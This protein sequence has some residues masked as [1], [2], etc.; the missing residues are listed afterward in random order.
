MAKLL[1]Q[2]RDTTQF[3]IHGAKSFRLAS[4]KLFNTFGG[5]LQNKNDSLKRLYWADKGKTINQ[6]DQSGAEALI[7]AY[8]CRDGN[9]RALFT[10]GVKPHVFVA[11][12]IFSDVWKEE[13]IRDGIDIHCDIDELLK[14]SI[15]D[16]KKNPWFKEVDKLIKSSDEWED[17]RR[18]YYIAKQVCHASNYGSSHHMLSLNTLDKS[19]GR[20][21]IPLKESKRFMDIYHGLFP[22]I[23]EDFQAYVRWCVEEN[24]MLYNLLGH[25][26]VMTCPTKGQMAQ[27][28]WK[29]WYA[30]I[31]QSTVAMITR[32][33][34]IKMQDFIEDTKV[35]WD[36]LPCDTHDSFAVQSP[37]SESEQ[38]QKIM[39]SF[40]EPELTN[41]KGETFQMK[42]EGKTGRCWAN[43][44]CSF[45]D[46]LKK[47]EI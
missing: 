25:P 27:S 10:N 5:N 46:G 31:S 28:L 17:E 3:L 14:L 37:E 42:S 26:L 1:N 15:P 4:R 12:H 7:V 33:A 29:E 35:N 19:N 32:T 8:L 38:C 40:I 21:V 2:P 41:F 22:E 9:F 36:I 23:Q 6:R 11:L 16:L 24:G 47:V 34:T 20:I 45:P 18:Y 44:S 13:I 39:K 30:L 43:F